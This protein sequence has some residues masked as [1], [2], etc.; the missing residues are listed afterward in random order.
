M[1]AKTKEEYDYIVI[2]S[3]AGG[4]PVAARLALAGYRVLVLEAGGDA[5]NANY[6]V[7]CF[8]PKASE[9]PELRWDF[10]VRHY[11]DD[12]RSH[13]DEKF[14]KEKDGVLYPRA[15]TLGGCTA[16][17][18][19]I[20]V[21]PQDCDWDYI[22]KL[23]GDASWK[24]ENMHKYFARLENCH[25]AP[26]PGSFKHLIRSVAWSLYAL[27]FGEAGMPGWQPRYVDA[28]HA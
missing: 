7:P 25:Y 2:G 5:E 20:T 6:R 15:G 18:A 22:A 1:T 19:M 27:F 17:N 11:A 14:V 13:R 26:R 16:H 8:H 3:G 21:T 28:T 4:G 12:A 10:F 9:D 24:A 23:T